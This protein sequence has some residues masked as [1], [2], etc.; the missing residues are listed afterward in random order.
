M[1]PELA[2]TPKPES[3]QDLDSSSQ[4]TTD[5]GLLYEC[6][7]RFPVPQPLGGALIWL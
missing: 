6:E 1:S 5:L 4:G 3:S 2:Q 7:L